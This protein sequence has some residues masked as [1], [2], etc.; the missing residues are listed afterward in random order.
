MRFFN[1]PY[2][3]RWA[4][5][6][7][8]K[9]LKAI[10]EVYNALKEDAEVQRWIEKIKLYKWVKLI[11]GEI[12]AGVGTHAILRIAQCY[13]TRTASRYGFAALTPNPCEFRIPANR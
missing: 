7:W 4:E 1:F 6:Y 5:L 9:Q 13:F 2:C 12:R 11:E 3:A 8:E 10:G